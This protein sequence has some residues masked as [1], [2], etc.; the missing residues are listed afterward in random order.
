MVSAADTVKMVE[1][2]ER[3]F[4]QST[5]SAAPSIA[6]SAR[7]PWTEK[8]ARR[9]TSRTARFCPARRHSR[10]CGRRLN[11]RAFLARSSCPC[12]QRK[13]RN[14]PCAGMVSTDV[15][16]SLI[17]YRTI[18]YI[19][20]GRTTRHS[21]HSAAGYGGWQGRRV[22]EV[23]PPVVLLS[24]LPPPWMGQELALLAIYSGRRCR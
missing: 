23:R 1:A 6:F 21:G 4:L 13:P 8:A 22:L 7:A 3:Q 20:D 17:T 10:A 11:L 2:P 12:R 14:L 15:M 16:Q 5:P 24:W 18:R 9:S 19:R